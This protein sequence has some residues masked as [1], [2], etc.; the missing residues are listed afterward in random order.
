MSRGDETERSLFLGRPGRANKD[1]QS[2]G[3]STQQGQPS[4]R[5]GPAPSKERHGVWDGGVEE[6][7]REQQ[8]DQEHRNEERASSTTDRTSQKRKEEK[9]RK[10]NH[11][12]DG[13]DV[14]WFSIGSATLAGG[15]PKP[16]S[17][18]GRRAY[19]VGAYAWPGPPGSAANG[20]AAWLLH[21]PPAMHVVTGKHTGARCERADQR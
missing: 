21:L 3:N 4:T 15:S 12:S 10:S 16:P 19:M 8:R 5:K 1:G 6:G 7:R 2:G 14:H 18:W 20:S 11:G 17:Q 13:G 9:A